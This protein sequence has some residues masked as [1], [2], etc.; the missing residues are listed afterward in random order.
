MVMSHGTLRVVAAQ[1]HGVT[2]DNVNCGVDNDNDVHEGDVDIERYPW[3]GVLYY[4]YEGEDGEARAVTTVSLIHAEFVIAPAA[5]LGPMPKDDFRSRTRVL[6]GEDWGGEG[7]RV[8]NYV[9]HPEYDE[10]YNTVA[11]VQLATTVRDIKI[12]PLC[13]PPERLRNPDFYIVK[14]AE[15]YNTLQ[16]QVIPVTH[17][18]ASLCKEFYVRANL[19]ARRM[20]P[21]HV[22]CAVTLEARVCVWDAGA[23]LV[24]RDVWGRWQLLGLGVRGPGCGAPSRYLD[25][26]SYYPWI[27]ASLDNFR[28]ITISKISQQKYVLRTGQVYQR[29]G[30]C[31]EEEKTNLLY[32]D[33]IYLT[34][35][36][37]LYQFLTYNMT[38]KENVEFTC[39]TLQLVNAS[40]VSEMRVHHYCRRESRG[41]PCYY[42]HGTVFEISVYLVF[43]DSCLFEMVGWGFKKSLKLLDIQEWKWEEGTYYED[44]SMTP[45]EYRGPS[46][47]TEF[48][49]EPLDIGMWVPD[50]DVWATTPAPGASSTVVRVATAGTPPPAVDWAYLPAYTEVWTTPPTLEPAW[51]DY[52]AGVTN[53]ARPTTPPTTEAANVTTTTNSP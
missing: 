52:M 12:K 25:M 26:M 47:Q 40:G 1:A 45:E 27:I 50:F 16:K 13:P 39:L 30:N 17:V 2:I 11:L 48:G 53:F 49:F 9:L 5:D 46:Y 43:S 18:P 44:F 20:R 32:R 3:L 23:A 33:R 19:Y 38:I 8:R 37:N 22:A 51:L 36:N 41:P 28:R 42:Y 31:D 14:F 35:D 34:T 15:D 21:P 10:T 29:F 7:R 24:A 4:S 6:L